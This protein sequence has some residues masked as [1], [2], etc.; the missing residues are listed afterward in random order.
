MV[1]GKASERA[2]NSKRNVLISNIIKLDLHLSASVVQ[3]YPCPSREIV[4]GE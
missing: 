1:D 4:G 3:I 2:G